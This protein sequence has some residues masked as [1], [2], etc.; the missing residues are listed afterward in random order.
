MSN[1][2]DDRNENAFKHAFDGALL[3]QIANS[4]S[5]YSFPFADCN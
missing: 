4:I 5:R 2:S 3:Q 1:I